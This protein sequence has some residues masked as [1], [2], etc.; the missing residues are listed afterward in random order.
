VDRFIQFVIFLIGISCISTFAFSDG[1]WSNSPIDPTP[2]LN[3]SRAELAQRFPGP[4]KAQLDKLVFQVDEIKSLQSLHQPTSANTIDP[5][6]L[7]NLTRDQLAEKFPTLSA[8][9][10]DLLQFK[11]AD[12]N[13][14]ASL[15]K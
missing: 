11:I 1:N 4:P 3:L 7:P 5:Y 12:I 8:R 15:K 2:L 9:D 13:S 6:A 14:I 10:L